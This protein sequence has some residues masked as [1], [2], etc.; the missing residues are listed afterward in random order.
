MR[1]VSNEAKRPVFALTID[2]EPNVRRMLADYGKWSGLEVAGPA[3]LDVLEEFNVPCTWFIT[4]DSWAKIN[5]SHP[6]LVERMASNGEIGCHVHFAEHDDVG[7]NDRYDVSAEYQRQAIETATQSLKTCGFTVR[8]F[9]GGSGYFDVNTLRILEQLDYMID[10]SVLP[11][12][13]TGNRIPGFV[14][15]HRRCALWYPYHPSRKD[16]CQPGDSSILEIPV[17]RY[18]VFQ[19]ETRIL[20]ILGYLNFSLKNCLLGDPFQA[21]TKLKALIRRNSL[22]YAIVFGYHTWEFLPTIETQLTNLRAFL[23]QSQAMGIHFC[24]L[25]EIARSYSV[26]KSQLSRSHLGFN[27]AISLDR[28][29]KLRKWI[30]LWR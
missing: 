17:F 2:V 23:K 26:P 14:V 5:C 28:L 19:V 21:L 1:E 13:Y 9:R 29:N 30:Q 27:L 12:L 20:R 8:S 4:H 22:N 15:D 3:L 10:S 16:H 6:A 24:V 11:G 18:P 7:N 25:S